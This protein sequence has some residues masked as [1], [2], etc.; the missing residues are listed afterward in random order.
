MPDF[1]VADTAA[2]HPKLR[3]AG[4][5]AAGL[6]SLAGAYAMRE[7]TDGWVPAYWVG[8]WPSGK[9]HAAKLIEV[10][11]WRAEERKGLPGYAFHDW[12]DIQ[13][14]AAS[15]HAERAEGRERARR[16]R[17][18][19]A[20]ERS[21]ERAPEAPP[22]VRSESH[23]SRALTRALTPG[24][25]SGE[26]TSGTERATPRDDPRPR[27]PEHANWPP[28]QRIPACGAC[29]QLR[30]EA[31]QHAADQQQHDLAQRAAWRAAVD[32]CPRCDERGL[33]ELDDDRVARCDHRPAP[34]AVAS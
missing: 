13:R 28:D 27:C 1:R 32:A 17:Q 22:D 2:E 25:S 30:L 7:L 31:E 18:Q 33:L 9:R 24:G 4:L 12:L 5:A 3:A 10:G 11:L 6:W 26:G 19:R 20:A 8:T 14:S 29:K 15:V 16:S 23:D 21:G 34:T